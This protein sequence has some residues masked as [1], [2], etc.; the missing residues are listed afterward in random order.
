MSIASQIAYVLRDTCPGL[1]TEAMAIAL[2]LELCPAPATRYRF[3]QTT[4][5]V[6][7]DSLAAPAVQERCIQRAIVCHVL[8]ALGLKLPRDVALADVVRD[9]FGTKASVVHV[10]RLAARRG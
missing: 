2:R 8:D 4:M 6:E 9:V 7:Y 10:V 5:R 3:V 1:S